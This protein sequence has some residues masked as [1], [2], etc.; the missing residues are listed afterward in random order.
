M[1]VMA[2]DGLLKWVGYLV[3]TVFPGLCQ[4]TI[5]GVGFLVQSSLISVGHTG[6]ESYS[7]IRGVRIILS[8][9]YTRGNRKELTK[10]LPAGAW[11]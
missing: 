3:V 1:A 6:N 11:T 10:E 5:A 4:G 2:G 7:F 9:G 8:I